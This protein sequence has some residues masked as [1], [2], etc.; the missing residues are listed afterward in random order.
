MRLLIVDDEEEFCEFVCMTLERD[1]H[2]VFSAFSY[3][4]AVSSLE[5]NSTFDAILSDL[6][7][8]G[9]G[10]IELLVFFAS[11]FP[12]AK[13]ALISGWLEPE[14]IPSELAGKI[15]CFEKPFSMATIRDW[16]NS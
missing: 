14:R 3:D 16:I 15:Q 10:G 7:L 9:K 6:N 2:E 12:E 5:E 4:G 11:K 1:G 13:L 8:D